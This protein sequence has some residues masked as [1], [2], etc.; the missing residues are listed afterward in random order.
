MAE[1]SSTAVRPLLREQQR[2]TIAYQCVAEVLKSPKDAAPAY[3]G[4]VLAVGVDIRRLGL[5]G[6]LA[7]LERDK[8]GKQLLAHLA[9]APMR[10]R[11]PRHEE[12]AAWVRDLDLA[13]YMVVTR[14]LLQFV[15]WLR[16]A[17]QALVK[18]T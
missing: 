3:K 15:V 7:V 1:P 14:E 18:D 10:T 5:S 12:I 13:S 17:V 6:A 4:L 11:P 2:T 9:R 16:R 8:D